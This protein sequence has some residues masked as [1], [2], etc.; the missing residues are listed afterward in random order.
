[1]S[2]EIGLTTLGLDVTVEILRAQHRDEQLRTGNI[3]AAERSWFFTLHFDAT[4]TDLLA[5][6]GVK[7][8]RLP[9]RDTQKLQ[10]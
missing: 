9:R 8:E 7:N 5:C 10:L 2:L 3:V 4:G 6:S 1:M